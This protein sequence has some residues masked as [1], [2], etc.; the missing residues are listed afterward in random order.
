MSIKATNIFVGTTENG[1]CT[2]P[3]GIRITFFSASTHLD[4]SF[5]GI[6]SY[7]DG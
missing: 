3:L 7:V 1:K 6:D 5:P 4:Y 2:G